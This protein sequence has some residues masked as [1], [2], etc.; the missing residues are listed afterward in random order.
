MFLDNC[1]E[2]DDLKL[3]V[4]GLNNGADEASGALPGSEQLSNVSRE[5]SSNQEFNDYAQ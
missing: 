5:L 3:Q 1:V 4:R 2:S